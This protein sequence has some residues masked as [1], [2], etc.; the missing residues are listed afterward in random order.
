[1]SE[2]PL[3]P[4]GALSTDQG[5]KLE[6]I[7]F[8]S[9]ESTAHACTDRA[10]FNEYTKFVSKV[11]FW[12]LGGYHELSVHGIGT[13]KL[14]IKNRPGVS[15]GTPQRILR[16][17]DVL[18]VPDL[19]VNVIAAQPAIGAWISP[20]INSYIYDNEKN[21]VAY[22]PFSQN[23]LLGEPGDSARHLLET[24][25]QS[26]RSLIEPCVRL[27]R[28]IGPVVEPSNYPVESR[29]ALSDFPSYYV[30][31]RII[32]WKELERLRWRAYKCMRKESAMPTHDPT[33]SNAEDARKPLKRM[34]IT[35][36]TG[37]GVSSNL[38]ESGASRT[39]QHA[40]NS[41][42]KVK[43]NDNVVSRSP[44]YSSSELE[45]L[46]ENGLTPGD[47]E[48]RNGG[49]SSESATIPIEFDEEDRECTFEVIQSQ[50][51]PDAS[52]RNDKPSQFTDKKYSKYMREKYPNIDKF[53]EALQLDI[54]KADD[55]DKAHSIIRSCIG[56]PVPAPSVSSATDPLGALWLAGMGTTDECCESSTES[57]NMDLVS[58]VCAEMEGMNKGGAAIHQSRRLGLP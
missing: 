15:D 12:S 13:V 31:R 43:F 28:P 57:E 21:L 25:E 50:P 53:F 51:T 1:M 6:P 26:P 27:D 54:Y 37:N 10:F 14:A 5:S 11:L 52:R 42:K 48:H 24:S 45:Y 36:N 29:I 7:W 16:L 17:V 33:T 44:P 35:S 30:G 4:R 34:R 49:C 47:A 22:F 32:C 3:S 20:K 56:S 58:R 19:P 9:G 8:W 38:T 41:H 46:K 39:A 23:R 40:Q 2:T 55:W 18:H